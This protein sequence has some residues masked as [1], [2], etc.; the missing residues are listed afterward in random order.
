[1]QY[2]K[3]LMYTSRLLGYAIISI[4]ILVPSLSNA[5]YSIAEENPQSEKLIKIEFFMR[6][7]C[8][9]CAKAELYLEK[10]TKRHPAV[11]IEYMDVENDIEAA[12]RL[13][14]LAVEHG[15]SAWGVPAFYIDRQ[16]IIGF[17]GDDSTGREIDTLVAERLTEDNETLVRVRNTLNIPIIGEVRVSDFGLPLF[18]VVI[19]LV[20]G[21]NPCA[22]WVLIFLLTLLVNLRSRTRMVL[23]AGVFVFVS[24]LVYFLFMAAWLN[25]FFLLALTR[26]LQLIL[27]VFAIA[28]GIIHIKDFIVFK[29]GLSLGIPEA[30]K[31][32]IYSRVNRIIRAENLTGAIV[33][34]IVLAA[35]VNIVELACTAGLPV[36]Y[37]HV[38]ANQ[39]LSPMEHYF[40]LILYN[41]AYMFDD[42]VMIIIAV[43]TLSRTRLQEKGGRVLKLV[44]GLAIS[45]LGLVL[46]LAPDWLSLL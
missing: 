46:I 34:V 6:A 19:G 13:N 42:S 3:L 10:L 45:L 14:E 26:T 16:L 44:S 33:T 15:Y 23:I 35:M 21:F 2:I 4:L 17:R 39:S 11:E 7:G 41:I 28:V 1:L 40:Y 18:T 30:A 29:K 36:I 37:T 5:L 12:I 24:G 22:M 31:P 32:G 25:F 27:G 20:D 8:Q 38:L 43:V 9:N